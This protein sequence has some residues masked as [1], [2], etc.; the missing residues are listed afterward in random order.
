VAE[1]PPGD[2]ERRIAAGT[3]QEVP[4]I[5]PVTALVFRTAIDDPARFRSR[6][7]G[8]YFG[9]TPRRFQSGTGI[10]WDGRISRQ[11]DD[12]VRG[13]SERP[14]GEEQGLVLDQG[15]G[16]ADPAAAHTRISVSASR[17]ASAAAPRYRI[18]RT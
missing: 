15:M 17:F 1:F 9:L 16:P 13:S 14:A 12:E 11:A 10:D 8:A 4:G 5:G 6:D 3:L 2:L 7:V 18:P